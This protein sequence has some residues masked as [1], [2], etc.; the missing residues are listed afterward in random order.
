MNSVKIVHISDLH[1]GN[2]SRVKADQLKDQILCNLPQLVI[3]SGDLVNHPLKKYYKL[4]KKYFDEFIEIGIEI[5]YAPGNHDRHIH[6]FLPFNFAPGFVGEFFPHPDEMKFV[7]FYK[8]NVP[9]S[10]FI[11]NSTIKGWPRWARGRI[12]SK[13]LESFKSTVD[14]LKR[15]Q[16]EHDNQKID[17]DI[18][19]ESLKIAV[20]HHHPLPIPYS[21]TENIVCLENSGTFLQEM[22]DGDIGVIL[23]GHKHFRFSSRWTASTTDGKLRHISLISPGSATK[24][25]KRQLEY[26][27][28]VITINEDRTIELECFH[29][30]NE[31]RNFTK[32][33][34]MSF[35]LLDV[36]G[37]KDS[38]YL[39]TLDRF[40]YK[41]KS[42]VKS[43]EL[44]EDGDSEI[45]IRYSG[46]RVT[47][48]N[49][50]K[51]SI[52]VNRGVSVGQISRNLSMNNPYYRWVK[53]EAGST[54]D[55]LLGVINFRELS[56]EDNGKNGEIDLE[57]CYRT[58][59]AHV[60]NN[61]EESL[62]YKTPSGCE[63]TSYLVD[64]P[65]ELLQ[66]V[67]KLPNSLE[68]QKNELQLCVYKDNK[69]YPNL[70]D[71][72]NLQYYK[73]LRT[74]VL[75]VF[76]PFL[77]YT[78][79][80]KW[81]IRQKVKDIDEPFQ[82]FAE[83]LKRRLLDIRY[84]GRSWTSEERT[85]QDT[86][87]RILTKFKEDLI[88]TFNIYDPVNEI[89]ISL[90]V[91]DENER[92]LY[93]ASCLFD[94]SHDLWG[95]SFPAGIGVAWHALKKKKMH[96]YVRKHAERSEAP[97]AGDLYIKPSELH[98]KGSFQH[99][100]LI[101]TPLCVHANRYP[102]GVLNIGSTFRESNLSI[103]SAEKEEIELKFGDL[104]DTLIAELIVLFDFAKAYIQTSKEVISAQRRN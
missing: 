8:F 42:I 24:P 11:F 94:Y 9:I 46:L 16:Y 23:H 52:K 39:K 12:S 22:I 53:D 19:N 7:P 14:K 73:G 100:I 18:F 74:I 83:V 43:V 10:V 87:R 41:C 3:V 55:K 68:V 29:S 34:G 17:I 36:L 25:D 37:A 51:S 102:F 79:R 56:K 40:G 27:F 61:E 78:Y 5:L 44:D 96:V 31:K 93:I 85:K 32:S 45:L 80:V 33:P 76:K 58:Y 65:T 98:C 82:N 63:Y 103:I 97:W 70:E 90:M 99:E 81:P 91:F 1:F 49:V 104:K 67:V 21:G 89:D 15:G 26:T 38:L 84:K 77:G 13:A 47:S 54:Y 4:A 88:S 92:K 57:Y 64:E 2:H 30:N 60:M 86:I 95:L 72:K 6:G 71:E 101:S 75:S 62:L 28:H 66:I 50:K 35:P 69:T 20:L 48:S 59:N